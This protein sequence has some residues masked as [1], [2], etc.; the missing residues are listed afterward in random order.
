MTADEDYD[1]EVETLAKKND[2]LRTELWQL[3]EEITRRLRNKG[4]LLPPLGSRVVQATNALYQTPEMKEHE[5][6]RREN[7]RLLKKLRENTSLIEVQ[8]IKDALAEKQKQI[9]EIELQNSTLEQVSRHQSKGLEHVTRLETELDEIARAH[10]RDV[11]QY[12]K[13]IKAERATRDEIQKQVTVN[14]VKIANLKTRISSAKSPLAE[15]WGSIDQLRQQLDKKDAILE[16]LTRQVEEA[17]KSNNTDEEL[18][19]LR[20]EY[21]ENTAEVQKLQSIIQETKQKVVETEK[22]L[23]MSAS[24]Y[25]WKFSRNSPTTGGAG[26][27]V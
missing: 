7:A 21:R 23:Q 8:E 17:R 25:L 19:Q 22:V 14:Q 20:K 1:K 11:M 15:K 16:D 4:E 26:S 2:E 9:D 27:P 10:S 5:K 6:A 18:K 3:N 13:D 12:K 24:P